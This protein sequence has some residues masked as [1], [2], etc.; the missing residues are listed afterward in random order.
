MDETKVKV[1][2]KEFQ[3][4]AVYKTTDGS[5]V[6]VSWP[7]RDQADGCVIMHGLLPALE[8]GQVIELQQHDGTDWKQVARFERIL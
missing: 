5:D 3:L 1:E 8:A 7:V 6:R 4:T 2:H